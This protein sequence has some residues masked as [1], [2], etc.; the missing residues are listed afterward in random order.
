MMKLHM[1]G[2][3]EVGAVVVIGMSVASAFAAEGDISPSY[4]IRMISSGLVFAATI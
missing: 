4:Q 3:F 2:R 1:I